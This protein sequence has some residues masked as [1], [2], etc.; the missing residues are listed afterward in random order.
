MKKGKQLI[1]NNSDSES[2]TPIVKPKKITA[3]T[4]KKQTRDDSEEPKKTTKKQTRDDSEEPKKTT[5]KQTRDDSEEPKKTTKKQ[6]RDDSEE[7]K[8][9]TKKQ[10]RDD[11]EEP[12]KTTK[13]QTRDDSEEPKKTTKKQT[14]DDSEEPKKTTKKQTRDDSE[15]PKKTT[16]DDSSDS[17][18][19]NDE[20]VKKQR[21]RP[22]KPIT[23][24]AKQP[25]IQKSVQE[26]E[27][28]QES[29]SIILH[30]PIYD[31]NDD[32][33][34]A[35]SETS[36]KN[37]F[38]MQGSD[39]ERPTGFQRF[40][41]LSDNESEES[42]VN[43]SQLKK[44]VKQLEQTIKKLRGDLETKTTREFESTMNTKLDIKK[45]NMKLVN[46]D[47]DTKTVIPEKTNI[48]CWWCT[49]NFDNIPCFIPEKLINNKYHVFGCFCSYN[50]ALAYIQKDDDSR[51]TNRISLI[52]KL[53]SE[54]Y[55]TKEP[56]LP[57]Y[58]KELLQKFGGPMS[59]ETYRAKKTIMTKDYKMIVGNMIP[60][61]LHLEE[62]PK[63][64]S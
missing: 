46:T 19:H 47:A 16:R 10:T 25:K 29:N 36:E 37:Q 23:Q 13:K 44:K 27:T 17:E 53:Y 39:T 63:I 61:S 24:M 11:S 43:T 4:T 45:I 3:K 49:Y 30:L 57:A 32:A 51:T 15:E 5:K 35:L 50:C 12:K 48:A 56:L 54:L 28:M 31:D 26:L 38:T 62:T 8:K 34:D 52:K 14:R 64:I 1:Q 55:N 7:P 40:M 18:E 59:I 42:D 20:Q 60:V 41:H 6:T 21:G 9:T 58:P 2:D 22:K 33:D